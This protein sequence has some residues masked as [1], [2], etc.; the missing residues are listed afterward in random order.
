MTKTTL[1]DCK[2]YLGKYYKLGPN[3]KVEIQSAGYRLIANI[4]SDELRRLG[5]EKIYIEM[6]LIS[7]NTTGG[8]AR[9][10]DALIWKERNQLTNG[11][12]LQETGIG[13]IEI[14][15]DLTEEGVIARIEEWTAHKMLTTDEPVTISTLRNRLR[16]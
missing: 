4:E 12:N 6:E 9:T 14:Q 11:I 15:E 2:E 13:H 10:L 16:K 3:D 8:M 7:R 5:I 1:E